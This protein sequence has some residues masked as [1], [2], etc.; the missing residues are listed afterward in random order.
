MDPKTRKL[1]T[2]SE[3]QTSY[4]KTKNEVES[5]IKFNLKKG[6]YDFWES[7]IINKG[8]EKIREKSEFDWESYVESYIKPREKKKLNF[9]HKTYLAPLTTVGNLPF[10]RICKGF[11]V[12]ITVSE[13]A[14]C[15]NLLQGQNTEW[16]LVKRHPCEDLFGIQ[17]AGN[18][19]DSMVRCAQLFNDLIDCDFVDINMG[20]P[21][22]A[23]YKNGGGSALMGSP[24]KLDRIVTGMSTILNCPLT[25]KIRTG[26]F[27]NKNVA[28]QLIPRLQKAGASAITLHGRSRQQRYTKLS[29]WEY[30][31]QCANIPD[32]TVPF[33][34]NGDVLSYTDYHERLQCNSIDGVMIGRGALIKPWIFEEI[35]ENKHKDISSKERFEMLKKFCDFGLEHWGSDT[36]GVNHTRRFLLEWQS[37]L[38]R[39]VPVGLLEVLP[40]KINH[41]P[42]LFVGR[43]ELETLMAS[44]NARDWLKI[45]EMLLGAAPDSFDFTPKHVSNSYK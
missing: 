23:V 28:H 15:T 16:A 11:G 14:M 10:R 44:G 22:D 17:V 36:Q 39:Y 29:D 8:L 42:P 7:N 2:N 20:C 35:K 19:P 30:I 27:D 45:S 5:N 4:K 37:F 41:R 34:G 38:Y 33:F 25:V 1:I 13:M 26:I 21:I 31:K 12:D 32:R 9:R 24:G 43:D 18:K 3:E 6:N 40:Q